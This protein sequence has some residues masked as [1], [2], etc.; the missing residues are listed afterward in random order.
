MSALHAH[1]RNG[2]IDDRG[3]ADRWCV[4]KRRRRTDVGRWLAGFLRDVAVQALGGV[5]AAGLVALLILL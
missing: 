1:T 4:A 2:E 3:G 5:I